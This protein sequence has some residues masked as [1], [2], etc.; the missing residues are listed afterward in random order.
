MRRATAG[1]VG[2][3]APGF[4][5][6]AEVARMLGMSTMTVYRA[7]ADEEFPAIKIRGRLIVPAKALEAMV[8]AATASQAPVDAADYVP[9]SAA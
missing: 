6:V 2:A 3:D 4:Y 7:I 5:S 1:H 8:D 9:P